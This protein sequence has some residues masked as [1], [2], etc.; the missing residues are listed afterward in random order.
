MFYPELL[1]RY[2]LI[3]KVHSS[4]FGNTYRSSDHLIFMLDKLKNDKE[5]SET[6]KHR[7]LGYVQGILTQLNLISVEEE[8]DFTR[9]IF[10]GK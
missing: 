5:M 4:K 1:E 8:R 9:N 7:W 6:K 10:K 3:I 2:K